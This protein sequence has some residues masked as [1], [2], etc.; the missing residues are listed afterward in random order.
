MLLK[1]A[2]MKQN[3]KSVLETEDPNDQVETLEHLLE[4]LHI[5]PHQPGPVQGNKDHQNDLHLEPAK[6]TGKVLGE[7]S[8]R[9][10]WTDPTEPPENS[11]FLLWIPVPGERFVQFVVESE[12]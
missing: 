3:G 11:P 9:S 12:G 5:E 6:R 1:P 4:V 10:G 7:E 2:T 8:H